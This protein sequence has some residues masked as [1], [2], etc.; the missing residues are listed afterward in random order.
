MK[1]STVEERTY[2]AAPLNQKE[3]ATIRAQYRK[4]DAFRGAEALAE[5]F[6]VPPADVVAVVNF[7][8]RKGKQKHDK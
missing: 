7:T 5:R 8:Y 3:Q 6:N 2:R 4:G 1:E